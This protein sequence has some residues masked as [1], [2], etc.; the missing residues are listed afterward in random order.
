MTVFTPADDAMIGE[1]ISL[2]IARLHFERFEI[3]NIRLTSAT[4]VDIHALHTLKS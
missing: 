4:V 2:R 1:T 3:V